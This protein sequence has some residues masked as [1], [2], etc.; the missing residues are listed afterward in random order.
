ME[1]EKRAIQ[2]RRLS[3]RER[4]A[5]INRMAAAMKRMRS[6]V[7]RMDSRS[8]ED[9]KVSYMMVSMQWDVVQELKGRLDR[10][11]RMKNLT[12]VG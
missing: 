12:M 2:E 3:P 4:A 5:M 1:R 7:L 6:L 11:A 10:D 8:G 9:H